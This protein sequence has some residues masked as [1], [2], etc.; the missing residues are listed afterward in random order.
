M[1]DNK[2]KCRKVDPKVVAYIAGGAVLGG[3]AGYLVNRIG[4]KNIAKMLKD[5]NILSS[6]IGSFVEDFDLKSFVSKAKKDLNDITED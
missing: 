3:L 5:K 2:Q 6:E 4:F 1:Y